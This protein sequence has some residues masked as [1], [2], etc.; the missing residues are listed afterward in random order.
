MKI[1]NI[2]VIKPPLKT[3]QIGV[4]FI[5]VEVR[6]DLGEDEQNEGR[7]ILVDIANEVEKM[8]YWRMDIGDDDWSLAFQPDIILKKSFNMDEMYDELSF[9][10][11]P[12]F[13]N[14]D[15]LHILG[16]VLVMTLYPSQVELFSIDEESLISFEGSFE[17]IEREELT[18]YEGMKAIGKLILEIPN[19]E[20]PND[21]KIKK[22]YVNINIQKNKVEYSIEPLIDKKIDFYTLIKTISDFA[23]RFIDLGYQV[24]GSIG[25]ASHKYIIYGD[26]ILVKA[27]KV[28]I[29]DK[30]IIVEEPVFE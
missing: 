8:K 11:T 5:G 26:Q 6:D 19:K 22:E 16:N 17:T 13:D 2:P 27:I 1:T 18:K 29:Q 3:L 12:F 25:L 7:E 14:S 24:K 23:N 15:Y 28:T 10:L 4:G 30:D 21:L 20:I 9:T